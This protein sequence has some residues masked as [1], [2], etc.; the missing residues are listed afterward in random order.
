[1][2]EVKTELVV[3]YTAIINL[4]WVLRNLVAEYVVHSSRILIQPVDRPEEKVT[5]IFGDEFYI[6]ECD[7]KRIS[8]R[9]EGPRTSYDDENGPLRFFFEILR[10]LK[11][12]DGFG[13]ANRATL[14]CWD[15]V[16]EIAGALSVHDFQ[17]AYLSEALGERFEKISDVAIEL[18]QEMKRVKRSLKFGFFLYAHDPDK[19]GLR[20]FEVG[21]AV[22]FEGIEGILTSIQVETEHVDFDH[23]LYLSLRRHYSELKNLLN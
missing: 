16:E 8:F 15:I 11:D 17:K 12:I 14:V 10:K 7:W 2:I 22:D 21:N 23:G 9:S 18:V 3:E 13:K 20:I 5:L 6:I 1:M 4:Q 19:H